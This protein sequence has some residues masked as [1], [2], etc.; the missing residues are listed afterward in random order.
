MIMVLVRSVANQK[1]SKPHAL[2]AKRIA[3][4]VPF[5]IKILAL[6][7]TQRNAASGVQKVKNLIHTNSANALMMQTTM[8]SQVMTS[9]HSVVVQPTFHVLRA[10][11][12]AKVVRSSIKR[13]ALVLTH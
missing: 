11:K 10:R 5:S 13:N 7:L 1:S 12:I 6:A 2:R 8:R 4:D 9:D 3:L